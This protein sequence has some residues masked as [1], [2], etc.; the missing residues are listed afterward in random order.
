MERERGNG[1]RKSR[2]RDKNEREVLE[3]RFII[4]LFFLDEGVYVDS[5][6]RS[7][8]DARLHWGEEPSSVGKFTCQSMCV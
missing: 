7:T 4:N 8:K 6:G 5:E 1:K 3:D 2:G